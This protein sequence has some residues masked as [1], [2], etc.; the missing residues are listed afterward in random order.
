MCNFT[1]FTRCAIEIGRAVVREI[2]SLV[3][4]KSNIIPNVSR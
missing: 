2:A 4:V 1:N 3:V